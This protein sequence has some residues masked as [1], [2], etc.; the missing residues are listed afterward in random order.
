[1]KKSEKLHSQ[2]REPPTHETVAIALTKI[3]DYDGSERTGEQRPSDRQFR[4]ASQYDQ[5][6]VCSRLFLEISSLA[7]SSQKYI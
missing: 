4:Q 1:M 6:N 2:S 5:L 7:N 3:R